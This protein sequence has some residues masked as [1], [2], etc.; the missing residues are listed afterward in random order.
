MI[1]VYRNI[2]DQAASVKIAALELDRI[3]ETAGS[4][5]GMKEFFY[6]NFKMP[7]AKIRLENEKSVLSLLESIDESRRKISNEYSGL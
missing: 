1:R 5:T 7:L 3:T 6:K 2:E 4:A